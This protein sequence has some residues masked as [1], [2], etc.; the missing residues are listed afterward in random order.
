MLLSTILCTLIVS[1][2]T[3]TTT[4]IWKKCFD[5]DNDP[6]PLQTLRFTTRSTIGAEGANPDCRL[7]TRPTINGNLIF[8]KVEWPES[9]D[10]PFMQIAVNENTLELLYTCGPVVKSPIIND[11][12]NGVFLYYRIYP[13]INGT[14]IYIDDELYCSWS[15]DMNN[16]SFPFQL[17]DQPQYYISDR[18]YQIYY[19]LTQT[20]PIAQ[21]NYAQLPASAGQFVDG[22]PYK[23]IGSEKYLFITRVADKT[24]DFLLEINGETPKLVQ[25]NLINDNSLSIK[26]ELNF[27]KRTMSAYA[28]ALK[29]EDNLR[30]K[31]LNSSID[32]NECRWSF[33]D[34][35]HTLYGPINL[36][37]TT[38]ELQIIENNMFAHVDQTNF[39][40]SSGSRSLKIVK[41]LLISILLSMCFLSR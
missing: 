35:I 15:L 34:P 1:Q 31:I 26:I 8:A 24:I 12:V 37:E 27:N 2:L 33:A 39:K 40:I 19:N 18:G 25:V 9:N 10:S 14:S 3:T 21:A 16:S 28:R 23:A 41:S 36:K 6:C 4:T 32:G 5:S 20:V 22:Y 17:I 30:D 7:T 38:Y 29:L 11:T 13:K